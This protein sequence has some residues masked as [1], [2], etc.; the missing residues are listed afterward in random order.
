MPTDAHDLD[1]VKRIIN[2]G[3]RDFAGSNPRWNW[4]PPTFT[5]QFDSAG[6]TTRSVDDSAFP[7]PLQDRTI[8]RAA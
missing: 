3:W 8:P 4:L 5:I 7:D 6:S 1:R 2:D